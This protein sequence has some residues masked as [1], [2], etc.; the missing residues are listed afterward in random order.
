MDIPQQYSNSSSKELNHSNS[1][2]QLSVSEVFSNLTDVIKPDDDYI[3]FYIKKYKELGHL[4]FM[5]L[6][7]KARAGS[8]TPDRLFFWMLKNPDLVR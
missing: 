3:P 8:D 6:V 4:K 1:T 2:V 7:G 5:W